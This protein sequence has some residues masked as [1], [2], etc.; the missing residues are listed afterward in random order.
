MSRLNEQ[1]MLSRDVTAITVPAGAPY[2]LRKGA[3]VWITQALGGSYTVIADG[4]MM[5]IDGSD[6]D[7][8]GQEKTA[9]PTVAEGQKIEDVV[10]EQLKKVFDPEIP[11]NI[12]DLG[13]VYACEVT[14]V[15]GGKKVD[16]KMAMTAP[17]CGM[18]DVLK[19][20]AERYLMQ[21]PGVVEATAEVVFEPPWDPTR[22]SE[23]ARLELGM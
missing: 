9:A 5:R 2:P 12:V 6:G 1:A 3:A 17:G 23:A 11:V 21:V 8:I 10:W 13:L 18:G 22:M 4:V 15:D 19:G 7:A 20:D 14:D 16:V